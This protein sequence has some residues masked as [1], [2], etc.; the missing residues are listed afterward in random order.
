MKKYIKYSAFLFVLFT[1]ILVERSA[2]KS[3]DNRLNN[4]TKLHFYC[5]HDDMTNTAMPIIR[6]LNASAPV[7]HLMRSQLAE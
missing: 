1:I 6:T 4:L 2:V 5:F 3:A 7:M